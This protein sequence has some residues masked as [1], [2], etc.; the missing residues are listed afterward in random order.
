[1]TNAAAAQR[2][3]QTRREIY[4]QLQQAVRENSPFVVMLQGNRL[5]AVRN[6]ILNVRQSIANSMLYFD[7]IIK[8]K[9]EIPTSP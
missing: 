6:N 9:V 1:M 2:D 3:P 5:V 8:E 7:E 4:L